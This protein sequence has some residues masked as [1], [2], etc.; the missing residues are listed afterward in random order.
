VQ[1]NL[2]IFA[3]WGHRIEEISSQYMQRQDSLLTA[4]TIF[5]SAQDGNTALMLA[6]ANGYDA[7]A[8]LLREAGA[9]PRAVRTSLHSPPWAEDENENI[10]D[11]T[12]L[13]ALNASASK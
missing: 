4:H 9:V 10:A 11:M 6:T 7:V 13:Q 1:L 12:L 8:A 2:R 5:T 3:N